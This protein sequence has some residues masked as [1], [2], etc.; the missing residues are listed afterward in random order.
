V[1]YS[2]DCFVMCHRSKNE[3]GVVARASIIL[4]AV[5]YLDFY[6]PQVIFQ[7][8]DSQNFSASA[9]QTMFANTGCGYALVL[10]MKFS[11]PD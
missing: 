3:G 5:L 1:A 4:I 8:S 6:S 2:Q 10:A 7:V 9:Q 11:N